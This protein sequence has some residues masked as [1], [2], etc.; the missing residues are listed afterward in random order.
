MRDARDPQAKLRIYLDPN[1][2]VP[3]EIV[4]RVPRVSPLPMTTTILDYQRL[5]LTAQSKQL[6]AMRPHPRARRICT[7]AIRP[8][9]RVSQ[10]CRTP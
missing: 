6:L 2:G 7:V 5:A 8:N 3:V 9:R 1:T 4:Q 10:H